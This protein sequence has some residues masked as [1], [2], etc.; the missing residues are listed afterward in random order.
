M[1]QQTKGMN[2]CTCC[3]MCCPNEQV[4]GILDTYNRPRNEFMSIPKDMSIP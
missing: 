4:I 2:D 1:E 3:L